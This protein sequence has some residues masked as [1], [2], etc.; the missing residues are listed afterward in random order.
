MET[1][2]A[3]VEE[4]AHMAV[5]V[6][7][8]YINPESGLFHQYL[9]PGVH[10]CLWEGCVFGGGDEGRGSGAFLTSVGEPDLALGRGRGGPGAGDLGCRVGLCVD[11]L[12][13]TQPLPWRERK[14]ERERESFI[15]NCPI[16]RGVWRS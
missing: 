13:P 5:E 14:R 7:G 4:E 12:A 11:G 8:L 10:V 1:R 6:W 9:N 3:G 15:R 2:M 16:T